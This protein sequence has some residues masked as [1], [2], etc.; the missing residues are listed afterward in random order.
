MIFTS[1]GHIF[2]EAAGSFDLALDTVNILAAVNDIVMEDLE[3][4]S[5]K[6]TAEEEVRYMMAWIGRAALLSADDLEAHL[7]D[8]KEGK[9]TFKELFEGICELAASSEESPQTEKKPYPLPGGKERK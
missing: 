7:K 9:A 3:A 1:D 4:R 5:C 2:T 6:R 8:F